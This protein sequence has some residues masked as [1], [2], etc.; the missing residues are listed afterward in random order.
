MMADL[1]DSR[2]EPTP[3]SITLTKSMLL[4][5]VCGMGRHTAP[6][7]ACLTDAQMIA[8]PFHV[9]WAQSIA[10][11]AWAMHRLTRLSRRIAGPRHIGS[12]Q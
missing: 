9:A 2:P 7:A 5:D 6:V 3:T 4:A 1:E 12:M 8:K 10:V 11:S